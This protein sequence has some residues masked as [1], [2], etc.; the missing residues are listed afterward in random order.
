MSVRI[1]LS[2]R[3]PAAAL[4]LT[5]GGAAHA[6][7]AD[8]AGAEIV[9]TGQLPAAANPFADAHAAYKVD[10]SASAKL[11]EPLADTPKSITIIPKEVIE[12]L[13]A[14]SFRDLVRTQPG[15]TLG[16]G[17]GGN[18]F[19]DRIFIRGFDARNDVYID[20][21]RDPGVT[22]REVFAVE[23][24]EIV[25]GPSSSFGGRGTTGGA[26]SLISKTPQTRDFALV[27]GT[28]GTDATARFTADVNR[29]LGE[30]VQARVNG[31]FHDA[32]VAGRDRVHN[33]RWGVAA[34][35]AWQPAPSVDVLVDYYHLTADGVPDWGHPFDVRTQQPFKVDRGN[36]YGVL[37]R[38][39]L[40]GRADIGT[41]RA[42]WRAGE[43]LRLDTKTRYG[44]NRNSYIASAP[45]S[46]D[47]SNPDPSKWTV[48]A[49]PKNRNA[50]S[51]TWAN[52]TDL[53][54]D[55]DTG[56]FHHS[57]VSGV[58]FSREKVINRPYAFASSETVGAV[59]VPTQII[60]QNLFA[61]N[62]DIAFSQFR[63]LSGARTETKVVSKA[64]YALDTVDLT[65]T[66][67]LSGGLRWDDYK[68]RL[69]SLATTGV[70]TLTR[71]DSDFVNW[72]AGLVWKPAPAATLYLSA[73]TSSNPS[74]EQTDGNGIS[75]GGLAASTANLAPERN[76]SYEAGAKYAAG[77]GGHLLLTAAVFR[78]DK[79]NARVSD[80][81]SGLQLLV[82]QQRVTGFEVGAQGNLTPRLALFGGYTYLDATVRPTPLQPGGVFPNI[83]KHSLALLTTYKLFDSVTIG[84]QAN[85]N[86]RRFGGSTIGGTANLPAYWRFDATAKASVSSRVEVQ[87]NLLNLTDKTYYDAIY[88]SGTPFAYVAPGRSALVTVRVS[89]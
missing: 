42:T 21:L 23:Q 26:V 6:D 46:P 8:D 34:S 9:V 15:I 63:T 80:P 5:L 75:Y 14:K 4:A 10:R 52:A 72:N 2:L 1:P 37:G 7:A 62:P 89:L 49:N 32:D 59:I 12:D 82:G 25:K 81:V 36:F 40:E 39:F 71:N 13:G 73:A 65:P 27:E 45:E 50:T 48:R 60:L 17:E 19:G 47:L 67:K 84:G 11:T 68:V 51:A 35:L 88:R 24:V 54:A 56:P 38:D 16:T 43:H 55:F 28:G 87:L 77:Q 41:V 70:T 53:T 69:D 29:K 22:S 74:G 76:K 57:L 18:A 86:S 83:P 33:R 61:P 58:E 64:V 3:F 31:V 85:Y 30:H 79:E 78:T 20:G 66:L 44:S